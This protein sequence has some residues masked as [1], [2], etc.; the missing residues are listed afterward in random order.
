MS[1]NGTKDC[2]IQKQGLMTADPSNAM[3]QVLKATGEHFVPR[4]RTPLPNNS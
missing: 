2:N 1:T 3:Y 4:P